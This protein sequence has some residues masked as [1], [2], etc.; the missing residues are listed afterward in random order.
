ML[1]IC[2]E[3]AVIA[4]VIGCAPAIVSPDAGVY[5]HCKLYAMSSK[6]MDSV[7][8]ATLA[9]MDKLQLHVSDKMKDVFSAKVIAKSADGKI[10]TVKIKPEPGNKTS[11]NIQVGAFGNEEM[12]QKI[13]D[14][15]LVGLAIV[16]TK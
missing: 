11:F 5:Q 12:S 8:A 10:I 16:R 13:Y 7:Y 4:G 2:L 6:D 9:A 15:I 14:E 3:A 1:L